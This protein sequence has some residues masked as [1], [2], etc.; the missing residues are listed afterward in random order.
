MARPKTKAANNTPPRTATVTAIEPP[1]TEGQRAGV[2]S[3]GRA[4]GIME[5]IARHRDG[6]GLAELSKRVGL[7]NSTTFHLVKTMV[8]LGYVRQL[9]DTKRYRIGRPLFALAASA[10]DEVEMT[11]LASPV[12]EALSRETGEGTQ[13]AV[14]SGDAVVILARM[15]GQG[16]FQL[17][18]RVGGIRPAHCTAIG[19]MMLASL[20]PEQFERFLSRADLKANT[21]KSIVKASELRREI[22]A[23]RRAGM[24]TDNG[25]FDVE[26][27]CVALPVRDFSAQVIGAIGLS[28]PVWRLS[29]VVLEKHV[30]AVRTAA[31]RLSAEFGYTGVVEPRV[32]AAE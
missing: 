9:K 15:S 21:P 17:A 20:T 29:D 24:A 4:F 31:E 8:S 28:G 27:R 6:I 10:L 3:L 25:E 22:E 5:E 23:V 18:D 30:R 19:K 11:S 14:R 32:S 16:A 26:L 12:L 1:P 7:H 13:F 2:Q